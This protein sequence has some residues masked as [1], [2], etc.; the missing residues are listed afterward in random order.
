[1]LDDPDTRL[2]DYGPGVL[3]DSELLSFLLTRGGAPG[4]VALTT[5]RDLMAHA[6]SLAGLA[7]LH[8]RELV[9]VPGIGPSRARRVQALLAVASRVAERPV[10]RGAVFEGPRQIYESVRVRMGRSNTERFMAFLLDARLRKLGALE[11]CA[12][13]RNTV[14]VLP[15]DVF[16]PA[17]RA[18]AASV[19]L[20]HN[21]PSGDPTPSPEDVALTDRLCA[22][23]DLL[24][25]AVQDH[26]VVG[27]GRFASMAEMGLIELAP[28]GFE[29]PAADDWRLP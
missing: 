11:V 10:P 7:Q 26:I 27:D 21:H 24:G 20:V 23:G 5:A 18:R 1:M 6:G 15:C 9:E 13:G 19:V 25:I 17:V 12:G 3:T 8:E 29:G 2:R 22:A 16:E 28:V 14:S 4:P